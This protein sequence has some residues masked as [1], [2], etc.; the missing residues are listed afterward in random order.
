[1]LHRNR[2][3]VLRK[4]HHIKVTDTHYSVIPLL[5]MKSWGI[6]TTVGEMLFSSRFPDFVQKSEAR[7]LKNV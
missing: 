1:M 2:D 7:G 3:P 6:M 4:H 5:E